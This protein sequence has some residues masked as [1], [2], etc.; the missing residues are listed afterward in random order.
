MNNPLLRSTEVNPMRHSLR[1]NAMF[2]RLE[3]D[4]NPMYA[5][6]RTNKKS[7][8]STMSLAKSTY[9]RDAGAFSVT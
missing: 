2:P 1:S 7:N 5:S 3:V 4:E 6:T 8:R 9:V